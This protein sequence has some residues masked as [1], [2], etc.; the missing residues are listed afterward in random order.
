[1][2]PERHSDVVVTTSEQHS[3]LRERP[4]VHARW[5]F[6]AVDIPA[7]IV[8]EYIAGGEHWLLD[9]LRAQPATENLICAAMDNLLAQFMIVASPSYGSVWCGVGT[10]AATTLSASITASQV[11]IGVASHTNFPATGP[12]VILC[13]TEQMLVTGG[14]GTNTWTVT[15]GYNGTTA[16]THASAAA[17][18]GAPGYNDTALF[19]EIARAPMGTAAAVNNVAELDFVFSQSEANSTLLEAGAFYSATI[20]ANSG[21][22][23]NHASINLTKTSA[24]TLLVSVQ[25]TF[26]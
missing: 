8:R 19:N 15:R 3:S 14:Q 23:L 9:L 18:T 25:F 16:A 10:G 24:V 4:Q 26:Q 5:R 1:M 11:S 2:K 22:L 6:L 21:T 17:V 13:G 7:D 12:Y 20:A